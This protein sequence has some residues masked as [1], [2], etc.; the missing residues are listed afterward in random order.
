MGENMYEAA[1][2]YVEDLGFSL[3]PINQK[4]KKPVIDWKKY[5]TE[6]P[7]LD[8]LQGWFKSGKNG[9]GIVTGKLSNLFVVDFDKYKPDFSEE[10]AISLIPDNVVC[11]SVKTLRG[12]QHLY[13]QYPPGNITIKADI[14]PAIDYRGEGGYIVAPPTTNYDWETPLEECPP[15][16]LPLP[17]IEHI[18]EINKVQNIYTRGV[19]NAGNICQQMSTLSTNVYKQGRRDQDL[20][21]I[22]NLLIRAKCEPEYL[23][24]TLEIIALN[25]DPPFPLNEVEN[26]IKSAL[27]RA[28]RRERNLASEVREYILSTNGVFLSTEIDKRLQLSTREEM[29]NLSIILRRLCQET[30]PLIEKWGDKNGFWRRIDDTEELIDIFNVDVT[31]VDIRLPLKIHEYVTIH[32]SNVI[33]IAGESN[34]GK[35]SFCL[36]V[37]KM[38]KE[39]FKINYLSSEMQNGAELRIRLDEFGLPIDFWRPIK[40]EFRTDDFPSKIMPDAINI[41]DYLDEGSDAEAYKMPARIRAIAD[42]LKGGVALIAIQKAPNKDYGYGGAGTLNRARLYLTTTT[43]GVMTIVKG[44]IWRNKTINPNGLQCNYKLAA[45]CKYS[46]DPVSGWVKP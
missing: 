23:Y 3:F 20:F 12:G 33:M 31:P 38:N 42:K 29:K 14:A 22:A 25:C 19:D 41:I 26:K 28:S 40:F 15:P 45:G 1:R 46:I 34:A 39:N 24:K 43:K 21:H 27:E 13:F 32:K 2:H 44:K 16:P 30:P 5:Q 8:D 37:A 10:I 35:T 36:N 6:R 7:T 18:K 17:F 11:P 9:I 4:T